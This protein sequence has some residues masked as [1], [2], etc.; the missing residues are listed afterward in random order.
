[1]RPDKHSQLLY[2]ILVWY[3]DVFHISDAFLSWPGN[4]EVASSA[5]SATCFQH[6][7]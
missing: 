2:I 4:L 5:D 6:E 3:S 7:L 1:M